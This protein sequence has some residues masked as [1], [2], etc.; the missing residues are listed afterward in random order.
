MGVSGIK[1]SLR[2]ENFAFTFF[3]MFLIERADINMFQENHLHSETCLFYPRTV[4]VK[5][6]S[7]DHFTNSLS[8]ISGLSLTSRSS[9]VWLKLSESEITW[10]R[11]SPLFIYTQWSGSSISAHWGYKAP[12]R[13]CSPSLPSDPFEV[14]LSFSHTLNKQC[15]Q[16]L[17]DV[18]F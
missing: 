10:S 12:K 2:C 8:H 11:L 3:K 18:I 7:W 16:K 17:Q 4:T 1:I 13:S 6:T 9:G 5:T 14:K 15:F